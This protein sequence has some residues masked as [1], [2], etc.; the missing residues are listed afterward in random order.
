[1]KIVI[2]H[3][4]PKVGAYSIENLFHTLAD[5]L[6]NLGEEII[7][8]EVG[9]RT[10]LLSDIRAL[11]KLDADIY[12]VTGDVNYLVLFLPWHNTV[13]TVHDIGHFLFGL[14]GWKK[15]LYKWLWLLLPMRLARRVTAVSSA[16]RDH[17]VEYLGLSAKN[18]VV[19]DNCYSSQYK[20]IPQ[21]FNKNCPR[22]LQVGTK[23]YKNVPRLI[24]ALQDIPCRLI[25]IGELDADI[26]VALTETGV[27]FENYIG[28]S[29]EELFRQYA[30]ADMVSFVSIGEGFGVPII[31][32][33]AVGRP[34]ITA[35]IPP[36]YVA[37]GH[38][39]YLADP[40]DIN[41]IR[42]GIL[43]IIHDDEYR[44]HIVK[45]GF[46]NAERY[47]PKTVATYYFN[48]YFEIK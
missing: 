3:R 2:I 33:Q 27:Q 13:L 35:N 5:E 39:A 30:G 10:H 16:T 21:P 11:R 45:S 22:I 46:K 17:I 40:L 24:R 26:T 9:P 1:M 29:Q 31:E 44:G 7:E 6:R 48:Q 12:H 34:L 32:A 37:A 15:W 28:I 8:Y 4:Q 25:L 43:K 42:T 38:G 41:S 36:M 20:S 18:I 47:A 23:P 19:I 14:T